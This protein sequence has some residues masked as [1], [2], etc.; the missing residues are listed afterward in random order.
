MQDRLKRL[1]ITKIKENNEISKE[2]KQKGKNIA[3]ERERERKTNVKKKGNS[4]ALARRDSGAIFSIFQRDGYR[5]K[6]NA[7]SRYIIPI[8]LSRVIAYWT[9]GRAFI[10]RPLVPASVGSVIALFRAR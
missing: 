9:Y 4:K 5:V 1:K 7:I 6:F 2:K 10:F 3:S 8:I